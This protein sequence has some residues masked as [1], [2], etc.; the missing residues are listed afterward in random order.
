MK[1][2][3]L[4]VFVGVVAL[5][6][7]ACD[8]FDH[9]LEPS[10]G[11]LG[12]LEF[13]TS[14]P[15]IFAETTQAN[16]LELS[17]LF[18][19]EYSNNNMNKTDMMAYFG[20]FFQINPNALFSV[21]DV[22]ISS[23]FQIKWHFMVT[24]SNQTILADTT[25]ADFLI[26][27]GE[28]FVFYGNQNDKRKVMIELFTGQWCSNCPNAEEALH[29]LRMQYGSRFSYVEY[30]FNDQLATNNSPI[31]YYPFAGTLPFGIVNGNALL[32]YSAPSVEEVQTQIQNAIIPLLLEE[33]QVG[34]SGAEA[35]IVGTTLSGSV[36]IDL[37]S[38][39]TAENQKLVV[40]LLDDY[41]AEYPNHHGDPHHNIALKRVEVDLSSLNL[42]DPVNFEIND[43]NVLP[44]WYN[45]VLPED[46]TLM[47]WVQRLD[48][49][50]DQ[51][52]CKAHNVIE[53]SI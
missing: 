36:Q 13:E 6:F 49:P 18:S 25:F 51:N 46:L 24:S 50:Y 11:N 39:L 47:I 21:D 12:L 43:L 48:T 26:Q 22:Q 7:T 1:S 44:A 10:I 5:V 20:T 27:E 35:E 28:G 45:G 42:N 9:V 41:N 8:R 52:T 15:D 2:K 3:I 4:L 33:M 53:I 30:H 40:V 31:F 34:I 16:Y 19:D 29:N 14:L 23:S 32:F 38:S 37:A 17:S